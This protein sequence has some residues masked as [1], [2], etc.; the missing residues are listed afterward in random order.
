VHGITQ[1]EAF[2]DAAFP[3]ALLHLGGD[4]DE[5]PAAG[6][7][8]PEFLAMGF[9]DHT[10]PLTRPPVKGPDGIAAAGL[11]KPPVSDL[12]R[13]VVFRGDPGGWEKILSHNYQ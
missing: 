5:G 3:E 6:D 9:H 8:K 7:L 4:V 12:F 11:D 1:H 2:G 13:P 10:M